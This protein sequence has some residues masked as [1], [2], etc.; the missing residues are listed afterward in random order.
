M[1][2]QAKKISDDVGE[3]ETAVSAMNDSRAAYDAL[4]APFQAAKSALED[5]RNGVLKATEN[6]QA[7]QESLAEDVKA[8]TTPEAPPAP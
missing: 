7:W 8:Y 3:F 1:A 6:V 5:A 4:V 2:D